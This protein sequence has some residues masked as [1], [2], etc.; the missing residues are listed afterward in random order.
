MKPTRSTEVPHTLH[1]GSLRRLTSRSGH[2]TRTQ[3][4]RLSP[5]SASISSR[6]FWM[7]DRTPDLRNIPTASDA[8]PVNRN[9][10]ARSIHIGRGLA[11]EFIS[12]PLRAGGDGEVLA[13][14]Q[15]GGVCSRCRL[16]AATLLSPGPTFQPRAAPNTLWRLVRADATPLAT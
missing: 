4:N 2:K 8:D 7:R 14:L 15:C 10:M 1:M 5:G 6:S 16:P 9:C 12:P 11:S 13:D 3:A